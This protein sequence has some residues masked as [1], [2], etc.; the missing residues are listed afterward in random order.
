MTGQPPKDH[1]TLVAHK[2]KYDTLCFPAESITLSEKARLKYI[3]NILPLGD[4]RLKILNFLDDNKNFKTHFSL[5]QPAKN[6]PLTHQEL[7]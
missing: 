1:S 2:C 3:Y 7:E 6:F 4:T 5:R